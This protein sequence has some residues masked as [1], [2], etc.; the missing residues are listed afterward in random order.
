MA[1]DPQSH[2]AILNTMNLAG[3]AR[4]FPSGD[5]A[6]LKRAG[7]PDEVAPMIGAPFGMQRP[8]SSKAICSRGLRAHCWCSGAC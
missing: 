5:Y 4:L 7:G 3:Y 2:L 8:I 1:Y 6:A